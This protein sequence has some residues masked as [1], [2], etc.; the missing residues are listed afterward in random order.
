MKLKCLEIVGL[1]KRLLNFLR[2]SGKLRAI[3]FEKT[4]K[5]EEYNQEIDGIVRGILKV[6]EKVAFIRKY[7]KLR[8]EEIAP[9]KLP[10]A[11]SE[12]KFEELKAGILELEAEIAELSRIKKELQKILPEVGG[13]VMVLCMKIPKDAVILLEKTLEEKEGI[14][15]FLLSEENAATII[16]VFPAEKA[17]E[18][19]DLIKTTGGSSLEIFLEKRKAVEA[20]K[21]VEE[22]ITA[23]RKK[24][25]DFVLKHEKDAKKL[26]AHYM[27]VYNELRKKFELLNIARNLETTEFFFRA[28]VWVPEEKLPEFLEVAK[29]Y[30][31]GVKELKRK[32]EEVPRIVVTTDAV[33]E[34]LT[35]FLPLMPYTPYLPTVSFLTFSAFF[36]VML[37]DVGYGL[38]LLLAGILW[39]DKIN[40]IFRRTFGIKND[41]S[42]VIIASAVFSII[43][44][45]VYGEFFG[46]LPKYLGI[47]YTGF[48]PR[49]ENP[50][51][52]ILT[53]A[54]A[55]AVHLTLSFFLKFI[56]WLRTGRFYPFFPSLVLAWILAL[57]GHWKLGLLLLALG[58]VASGLKEFVELPSYFTNV[59]SYTR[60]AAIGLVAAYLAQVIN[61]FAFS[62]PLAAGLLVFFLGHAFNFIFAVF[63]PFIQTLRLHLVEFLSKLT[64]GG[65][66]IFTPLVI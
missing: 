59:I 7:W 14:K 40:A 13:E 57:E 47:S 39:R 62:L 5:N 2:D 15:A 41:F 23:A 55:G 9:K 63:D 6:K 52:L 53:T 33:S 60:L 28:V 12:K 31:M 16:L 42:R 17:K 48:F 25:Q 43:F 22:K 30:R 4:G 3:H 29:K 45:A 32:P 1:K 34:L 36:G 20:I 64:E 8:G 46:D 49:L 54:I 19:E 44:G 10:A 37:G 27:A 18:V 51:M 66:K 24:L 61:H 50:E 58:S 35:S 26:I 65:R 21:A 11:A 56:S 38:L